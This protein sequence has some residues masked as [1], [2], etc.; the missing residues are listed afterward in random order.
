MLICQVLIVLQKNV[1]E[2]VE[3]L[4]SRGIEV[5][6]VVCHVSVAQQRKNLVE[7]LFR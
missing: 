6:G 5:F 7:R 1:D 3:K 4:K 2:A